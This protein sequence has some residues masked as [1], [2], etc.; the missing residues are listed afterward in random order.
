MNEISRTRLESALFLSP[1]EL[2]HCNKY[3]ILHWSGEYILAKTGDWPAKGDRDIILNQDIIYEVFFAKGLTPLDVVQQ[4]ARQYRVSF[5]RAKGD[6]FGV[7]LIATCTT[8]TE[9]SDY[10]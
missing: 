6:T 4:P 2:L 5:R 7:A 1:L 8:R 10:E 9:V 3:Y